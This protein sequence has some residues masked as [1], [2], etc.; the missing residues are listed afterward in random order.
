LLQSLQLPLAL[1]DVL[2]VPLD[3]DRLFEPPLEIFGGDLTVSGVPGFSGLETPFGRKTRLVERLAA[4]EHQSDAVLELAVADNRISVQEPHRVTVP[5]FALCVR[6]VSIDGP[7]EGVAN[8]LV[9]GRLGRVVSLNVLLDRHSSSSPKDR[10]CA[11]DTCNVR[12]CKEQP[13]E[14]SADGWRPD[15][16]SNDGMGN[17]DECSNRRG[18]HGNQQ[19]VTNGASPTGR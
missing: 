5:D 1:H 4:P 12:C 2:V 17:S 13:A 9:A 19:E 10:E 8:A 7:G 14:D 18:T 6:Q 16:P 3:L 15:K 11:K